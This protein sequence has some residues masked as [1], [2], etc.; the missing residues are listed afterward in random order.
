MTRASTPTQT[1]G[2]YFSLGL[3]PG[4]DNVLAR[5]DTPGEAIR[6]E[7]RVFDGDGDPLF[8]VLLEVWQANAEGRYAH[9]L[10]LWPLPADPDFIG[11]GRASTNAEGHYWFET[12]K[13]GPVPANEGGEQAPHILLLVHASGIPYPLVTRIYFAGD[14]RNETDPFLLRI[15]EER[16]ATLV[17]PRMEGAGASVYR[18]DIVLRG[19]A[20]E[21]VLE[22]KVVGKARENVVEDAPTAETVF[23]AVQ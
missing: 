14:P 22:G 7:G 19:E 10:D 23:V 13:P 17:A 4:A 1:V 16:R 12:I 11:F 18:F 15:P 2:P 9:P 21:L 3:M 5:S 8:N 20:E 6:I